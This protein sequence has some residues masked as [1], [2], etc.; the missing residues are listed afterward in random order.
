MTRRS[1][2]TN[3][4]DGMLR[5]ARLG[6]GCKSPLNSLSEEV[7]ELS[8]S[9]PNWRIDHGR[10][11]SAYTLRPLSA[12]AGKAPAFDSAVNEG[13]RT[14]NDPVHV[15]C[16]E[17]NAVVAAAQ[18][19]QISM[20]FYRGHWTC[21][22]NSELV[23]SCR[24]MEGNETATLGVRHSL[25]TV[26]KPSRKRTAPASAGTRSDLDLLRRREPNRVERHGAR[27]GKARH[28]Y[29]DRCSGQQSRD[30]DLHRR[31]Q[32]PH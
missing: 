10:C 27:L 28:G 4:A 19:C 13:N 20:Q 12:L 1:F 15:L 16:G 5:K 17:A 11:R 2:R 8:N 3:E 22:W 30:T 14:V 25:A 9:V 18:D 24:E 23:F 7:T 29:S 6:L 21:T 31:R 32:C 26:K